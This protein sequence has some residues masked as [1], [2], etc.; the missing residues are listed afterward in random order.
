MSLLREQTTR[1]FKWSYLSLVISV[2][3][4][5]LFAAILAR[6]LTRQEFGVL[7]SGMVLFVLGNFVSDMGMGAAIVQKL[8]LTTKNIHAALTSALLLGLLM[9]VAGWF[10]APLAGHYFKNPEVTVVYRGFSLTYLILTVAGVSSNLLRRQ[11]NFRAIM[12]AELS[13]FLI[14]HGLFG[15]GSAALGYGAMSLV[16]SVFAQ[17]LLL[18][19]IT[20]TMSRF[21]FGLTSNWADFRELYAFGSRSTVANFADYV[22]Q[23]IDTFMIGRLYDLTTL[24][25]Y[26]RAFN[27]VCTPLMS[28]SRSITRVMDSSMS[29]VQNDPYRLRRAYT[30][31]VT[32][33]SVLLFPVALCIWVCAREIVL[34][35]LGNR[36]LAAVPVVMALALYIPFPILANLSSSLVT[37]TAKLNARIGI[38]VAY[39]GLLVLAFLGAHLLGYGLVG[40]AVALLLVSVLRCLAY[41]VLVGRITGGGLSESLRAYGVGMLGGLAVAAP[42][43]LVTVLLRQAHLALPLLFLAELLTGGVLL[44]LVLLLGP[45]TELQRVL[46]GRLRPLLARRHLLRKRIKV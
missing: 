36:F 27:T 19:V 45:P 11:L 40:F 13:A 29:A 16:I 43:L 22:S 35:L 6:L 9:T 14:G 41:A 33:L 7:A 2:L 28:F 21:P 32:T 12:I 10:L 37:A 30:L 44:L 1:A 18:L 4:Q 24:G 17:N 23:N 20:M 15:L 8:E 5:P 3:F 46:R 25:L 42:L 38:Q 26:N 31:S 34:V 39:L